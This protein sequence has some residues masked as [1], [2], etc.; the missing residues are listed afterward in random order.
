MNIFSSSPKRSAQRKH[1]PTALVPTER[2]HISAARLTGAEN[3]KESSSDGGFASLLM[4][5]LFS[6]PFTVILGLVFLLIST[7]VAYAQPDPDKF[8]LPLALGSLSLTALLGGLIAARRRQHHCLICG[9]LSGLLFTL[10]LLVLS[11]FL[12][13]D[14]QTPINAG[15]SGALSWAVHIGVLLLEALGALIGSRH[16]SKRHRHYHKSL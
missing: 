11:L 14:A 4:A 12:K 8:T 6:L 16:R 3:A 13:N 10:L 1:P 9:L 5:A 2:R 7:A 15:L